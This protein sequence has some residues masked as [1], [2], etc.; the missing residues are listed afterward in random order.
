MRLCAVAAIAILPFQAVAQ[1]TDASCQLT[2]SG[3]SKVTAVSFDPEGL[4][5]TAGADDWCTITRSGALTQG[6]KF[7][8]AKFRVDQLDIRQPKSRALELEVTNLQSAA[9]LFDI[10]IALSH[11][12]ETGLL[13]IHRA[14][15]R[16]GDGRGLRANGIFVL[17]PF[18]TIE[19][20]RAALLGLAMRSVSVEAVVT[21]AFFEDV[22]ADFQDVTHVSFRSALK[23][24]SQ[25]QVS[26]AS[27]N[28]FLRFAG[29]VP[30]ARGTVDVTLEAPSDVG[31]AQLIGPFLGLGRNPDDDALMMAL[32]TALTNVAVDIAWK[33]GRM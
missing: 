4:I 9:G 15:A 21:P 2:L 25:G 14:T 23:D 30:N 8:E 28:E 26:N 33:P 27:R 13:L 18:G 12:A 29:A 5:A 17:P 31:V 7:E 11:Q 10:S 19:Q 1:S 22:N 3:F 20:A 24:V 32:A 16:G 6:V